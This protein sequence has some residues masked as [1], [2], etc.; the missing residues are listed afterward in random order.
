MYAAHFAAALAIKGQVPRAPAAAVMLGAFLPDLVWVALG[1]AGIEPSQGPAF[2]DD[3]SH[4]LVM[5]AVFGAVYA[6]GFWQ[7]PAAVMFAVWLSVFSHFLLDVPIHPKNIA[8]FPHSA[9]HLGWGLWSFGQ[10][11]WLGATKYWWVEMAVLSVL[12]VVYIQG[13]RKA[14]I[15]SNLMAASC[16]LVLGLHLLGLLS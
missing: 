2:F 5:V 7:K 1:L 9:A 16:L 12:A 3:W 15:P 11:P 6:V 10:T 4:S 14:R 8:L 13:A